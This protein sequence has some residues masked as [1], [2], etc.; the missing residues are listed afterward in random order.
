VCEELDKPAGHVAQG[1]AQ[2]LGVESLLRLVVKHSKGD[3]VPLDCD[4]PLVMPSGQT[5]PVV[6]LVVSLHL[7]V[8]ERMIQDG[9][10]LFGAITP[11]VLAQGLLE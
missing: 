3:L 8:L 1:C 10:G 9:I 7:G 4:E 2:K 11:P 6:V 5:F